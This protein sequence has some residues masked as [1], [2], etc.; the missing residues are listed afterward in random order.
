MIKR[1]RATRGE[2]IRITSKG[3][4]ELSEMYL[5]LQRVIEEPKREMVAV[6]AVAPDSSIQLDRRA[7]GLSTPPI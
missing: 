5:T 7:L 6:D 2:T 1:E 4:Q 3:M